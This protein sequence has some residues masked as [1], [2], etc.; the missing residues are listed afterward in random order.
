MSDHW[1]WKAR[2]V[3]QKSVIRLHS[4][5]FFLMFACWGCTFA[6][7]DDA[8]MTWWRTGAGESGRTYLSTCLPSL[9]A[10]Q[11]NK[12]SHCLRCLCLGQVRKVTS[13][14]FGMCSLFCRFIA[15]NFLGHPRVH[16]KLDNQLFSIMGTDNCGGMSSKKV[17]LRN[18]WL[19]VPPV[20]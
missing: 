13:Q 16:Y 5:A 11:L 17:A 18:F 9:Y 4:E 8:V 15:L 3:R 7:N 12:L 14:G 1:P 6:G 2:G 10:F 20:A 19:Q